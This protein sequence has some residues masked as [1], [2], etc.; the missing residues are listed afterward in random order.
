MAPALVWPSERADRR[1][2]LAL[3]EEIV[4]K[5]SILIIRTRAGVRQA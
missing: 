3:R 5:D 4:G 1:G 2:C